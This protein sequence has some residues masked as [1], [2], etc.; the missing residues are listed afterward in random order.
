MKIR[1][2][3]LQFLR[4]L[5]FI[6]VFLLHACPEGIGPLSVQDLANCAFFSVSF[7]I[8]LSGFV[9]ALSTS[10]EISTWKDHVK[11][12]GKYLWKKLKQ[13]YPLYIVLL[14]MSLFYYLIPFLISRST[15]QIK[16][17][18]LQ[19]FK[20]ALL[21]ETWIDH[22][23]F[24]MVW[25]AWFLSVIFFMYILKYPLLGLI[26]RIE[27]KFSRNGLFVFLLCVISGDFFLQY[28]FHIHTF[29]SNPEFW[30]YVFPPSRVGE[31]LAGMITCR[32]M[33]PYFKQK[34]NQHL[35]W[36]TFLEMTALL[37]PVIMACSINTEEWLLR[38][39]IW[40]IPSML[41]IMVFSVEGGYLSRFFCHKILVYLGNIE[42][43]CYLLHESCIL[44]TG[45][46]FET[47][48]ALSMLVALVITVLTASVLYKW[49]KRGNQRKMTVQTS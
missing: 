35:L 4:F 19:Y 7:F 13:F 34:K 17:L 41:L 6:G 24:Y 23:Y 45:Y 28:L 25:A 14:T 15:T 26:Q 8:V 29:T 1:L 46:L 22:D 12:V 33:I 2:N 42:F 43:E 40:M 30:N 38:S 9:S 10:D 21:I 37:I 3:S 39:V 18:V 36:Y 5:A 44:L 47:G 11:T 48:Q 16:V 32:M 20:C 49:K 27:N 31:Y